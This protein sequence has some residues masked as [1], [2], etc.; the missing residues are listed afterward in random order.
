MILH[1]IGRLEM[2][3]VFDTAG[4]K[5]VEQNDA[6]AAVEKPLREV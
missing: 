2:A 6:V 1:A 5:V 4:G 3:D